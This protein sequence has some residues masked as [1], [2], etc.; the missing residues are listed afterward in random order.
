MVVGS[1]VATAAADPTR[2]AGPAVGAAGPSLMTGPSVEVAG[3]SLMADPAAAGPSSRS[4]PAGP[5]SRAHRE[6]TRAVIP[7]VVPV[8]EAAHSTRA[9]DPA[10]EA[11]TRDEHRRGAVRLWSASDCGDSIDTMTGNALTPYVCVPDARAALTWYADVFGATISMHPLVMEDGRV[12][13]AE[14]TV[15]GARLMLS[16]PFAEVPVAAPVAGQP[17]TVTL[18]LEVDDVDDLVRRVSD[19]G[20]TVTRPPGDT[21][22]G[23][24]AR[25]V[26][27][28]GHQWMLNQP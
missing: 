16:D 22:H 3:P 7:A 25:V 12:G 11:L 4:A 28:F 18:H 19:A 8:G 10:G 1:A 13:H 26:D 6:T 2:E 17:P 21:P 23:R 5:S 9:G 24:I 20:G 14:M 15:R 27:P